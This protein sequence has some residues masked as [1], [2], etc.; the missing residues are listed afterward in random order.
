MVIPLGNPRFFYMLG[1]LSGATLF[2]VRFQEQDFRHLAVQI[3]VGALFALA[4]G[5]YALAG[6]AAFSLSRAL[7]IATLLLSGMGFAWFSIQ[8]L[9]QLAR[10]GQYS[11]VVSTLVVSLLLKTALAATIS[12]FVPAP[13]QL[14]ITVSLPFLAAATLIASRSNLDAS[15]ASSALEAFPKISQPYRR[16]LLILLLMNSLLRAI[17]RLMSSMGLWGAGELPA[18]QMFIFDFAL[19][20]LLLSVAAYFT[21]ARQENPDPVARFLPA[22]LVI[23]AGFFILDPQVLELSRLS[24]SMAFVLNLSVELFA[25]LFFWTIIVFGIRSLDLQPFRVA[26]LAVALYAAISALLTFMLPAPDVAYRLIAVSMLYMFIVVLMLILRFAHPPDAARSPDAA[27]QQE[28]VTPSSDPPHLQKAPEE[29]Q[30][31]LTDELNAGAPAAPLQEIARSNGLSPRET[32]VFVLLAQ[33]R[34]RPYIQQQLF[35]ADGTVKTHTSRIYQKLGIANRQELITLVQQ[36]RDDFVG[37][38]L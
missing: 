36:Q 38:I 17:I 28:D 21:L 5:V 4:S 3:G 10:R 35:L 27:R 13:V 33:G 25:Y 29:E 20:A 9:T 24:S 11:T 37:R 6:T 7:A 30:R 8:L 15:G 12:L 31:L 34:S 23:L 2:A 16:A 18:S 14:A 19:L 1:L 32:E 26:G 22:F